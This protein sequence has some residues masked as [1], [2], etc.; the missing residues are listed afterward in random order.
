MGSIY[1][2]LTHP[3]AS[4]LPYL[5][6]QG[7]FQR[8]GHL[9]YRSLR[10]RLLWLDLNQQPALQWLCKPLSQW[11]GYVQKKNLSKFYKHDRGFQG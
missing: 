3:Q 2:N 1:Q 9:P 10:A 6:L 7:S 11:T 8:E 4:F 5:P